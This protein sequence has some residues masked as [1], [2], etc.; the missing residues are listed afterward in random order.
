MD[1]IKAGVE[2]IIEDEVTSR[3]EAEQLKSWNLLTRTNRQYEFINWKITL[4]WVFGFA[5]RYTILMP[6]RVLVCFIGVSIFG[7]CKRATICY[8]ILSSEYKAD[9]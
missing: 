9:K 7:K 8:N 6:L 5:V 3:F 2:A 4:I 1:Y